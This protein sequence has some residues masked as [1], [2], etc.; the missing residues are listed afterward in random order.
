MSAYV[1]DAIVLFGDSLTEA[2]WDEGGFGPRLANAY[3]RKLD[4]VNRGF[5]GYTTDWAIPVLEQ[6][7][8]DQEGQKHAPK[9]KIL[10]IWFGANDACIKP[11]IQHV[12][13]EKFKQNIKDMVDL[14][15]SPKSPYYSPSTRIIVI[16]PPPISTHLRAMDL[17]SRT[18]A[19]EMDREF[20]TTKAYAE[21]VKD[22]VAGCDV[23]L[24]DVWTEIWNAAGAQEEALDKYLSD[25][26]HLT[27]E[28]YKIVY[29]ALMKTIEEKY[30]DL[31]YKNLEYVFP[32]WREV[33][34]AN[35]RASVQK[36]ER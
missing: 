16:T 1:Q 36:R 30:P 9:V 32:G 3:S 7:L 13:L 26:L 12:P 19:L 11:S 33:D 6:C 35:I 31:H 17:A 25:G 18:P 23:A 27:A 21:G 22:A 8:A 10:T 34:P 14:V 28:G 24:V 5:A 2:I 29:D 20:E 4:V 15:Q